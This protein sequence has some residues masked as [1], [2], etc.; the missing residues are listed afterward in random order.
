MRDYRNHPGRKSELARL[1]MREVCA[2]RGITVA[3]LIGNTP[4]QF[5]NGEVDEARRRLDAQ[6]YQF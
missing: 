5:A 3:E 6:G 2:M 1:L 4:V